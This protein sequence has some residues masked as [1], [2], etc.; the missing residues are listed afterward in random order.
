MVS[1]SPAAVAPSGGRRASRVA[2]PFEDVGQ[3][4]AV[5]SLG[6]WIF[7]TTETL[8]FGVLFF[9][10]TIARLQASEAFA[11]ASRHTNLVLGTANTA[12]LLTSSLFMAL[13]V[14]NAALGTR[15]RA[16]AFL[17]VTAALGLI[18]TGIKLAEYALDYREQLVPLIN[19]AFDPRYASG[20]LVF[21]GLYF[22]T[23]GLHLVHLG[24]GIALVVFFAWR[25]LRSS[26]RNAAR[27][28]ETTGLY[29]HF[30]DIVWIFLY[31][32]LYLVA[33]S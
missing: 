19:F 28:I 30:V 23:T 6:M 11:E 24:I 14:R 8:F 25:V 5:V 29:W 9:A 33:R 22:V 17:L 16:A 7:L 2:E 31:P 10:Y 21:F 32:C 12:I 13:A 18:F 26:A 3:Q 15:K 27:S 1:A 20:A 4:R